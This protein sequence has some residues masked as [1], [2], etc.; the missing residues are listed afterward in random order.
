[1][2]YF[3]GFPHLRSLGHLQGIIQNEHGGQPSWRWNLND[4]PCASLVPTL[5]CADL[6]AS[7]HEFKCVARCLDRSTDVHSLGLSYS[8][9]PLPYN[10]YGLL[11][12][13]CLL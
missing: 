13:V 3:S 11:S 7:M 9:S 1:M 2:G 4:F 6:T 8:P 12:E 5:V 10:T